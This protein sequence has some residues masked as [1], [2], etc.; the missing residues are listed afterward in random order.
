MAVAFIGSWLGCAGHSRRSRNPVFSS[1]L[2]REA[3]DHRFRGDDASAGPLAV[4]ASGA[5]VT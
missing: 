5:S 2:A 3:R 4:R 1:L